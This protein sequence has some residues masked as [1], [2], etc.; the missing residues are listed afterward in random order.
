M[1]KSST[2]KKSTEPK[3]IKYTDKSA[4]Q[5]EMIKIFNDLHAMLTPYE[6][7]SLKKFGG[8]AGQVSLI[9]TKEV[10]IAGRKKS[11]L[12][13][14]GL[15]I[16]KGY[17]GFYFM[18]VYVEPEKKRLFGAELL[19]TLKGKSCF[20]IKSA[21]PLIYSQ[22]EQALKLGYEEWRKNGWV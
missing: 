20:H 14:A 7:G 8:E 5:P 22:I 4:D 11:D 10:E 17:V 16:Q 21:D 9:S 1:A 13:F 6:K 15:L 2:T 12:W 19:K 18:P 3:P